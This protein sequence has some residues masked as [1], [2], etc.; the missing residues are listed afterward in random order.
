MERRYNQIS[1]VYREA[2]SYKDSML[3]SS[4]DWLAFRDSMVSIDSTYEAII[5]S[6]RDQ[7]DNKT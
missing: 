2:D 7:K 1:R 6:F 3:R 5:D 4:Y